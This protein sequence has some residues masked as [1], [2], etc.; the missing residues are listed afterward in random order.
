MTGLTSTVEQPN[1]ERALLVGYFNVQTL[2]RLFLPMPIIE[3]EMCWSIII[4][5]LLYIYIHYCSIEYTSETVWYNTVG[6]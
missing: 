3:K 6:H 5:V 4:P 1:T 2:V